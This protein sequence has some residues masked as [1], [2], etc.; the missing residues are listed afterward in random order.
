MKRRLMT[1]LAIMLC[2]AAALS[3]MACDT[4]PAGGQDGKKTAEPTEVPIDWNSP[5]EYNMAKDAV[6]V[7]NI[8]LFS[9]FSSGDLAL[10]GFKFDL[11]PKGAAG[12][13]KLLISIDSNVITE[14]K[15]SGIPEDE[16]QFKYLSEDMKQCETGWNEPILIS[17][18]TPGVNSE[19]PEMM[20][21]VIIRDG[22]LI[23][24][25]A[26]IRF[27]RNA[28]YRAGLQH[29]A[30]VRSVLFE[31]DSMTLEQVNSILDRAESTMFDHVD[32][33]AIE[34]TKDDLFWS[35]GWE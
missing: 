30:V 26:L 7:M 28:K 17:A 2:I 5:E 21:R 18:K 25:Y 24:G 33:D 19:G 34:E 27:W 6:W 4:A 9:T 31:D 20:V 32:F 29:A 8:D 12:E 1:V 11:E 16:R 14:N 15:A 10:V 35:D 22:E 13:Q 3:M 23:R